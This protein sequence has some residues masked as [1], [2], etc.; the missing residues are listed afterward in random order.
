M[1]VQ[2]GK[3]VPVWGWAAPEEPVV[4]DWGGHTLRTQADLSGRWHLV[5]PAVAAG[6]VARFS[7]T[8][9]NRIEVKDVLAGEVWLGSGQSNMGFSVSRVEDFERV[10]AAANLPEIRM[11]VVEKK[12]ADKPEDDCVGRWIVCSP[13]SVGDFSAVAFFFGRTMHETM[14]GAVGLIV[15]SAGATPIESWISLAKQRTWPRF[16]KYADLLRTAPPKVSRSEASKQRALELAKLT[17]PGVLFN[18]MIAPLIPY[19]IRGVLWYQ[20]ESNANDRYVAFYE[21]QMR[22]LV[23]DWRA[24][25]GEELPFAWV[26]L[27]N[28]TARGRT[29]WPELR[30]AQRRA[31]TLPRTGMVVTID[32]GDPNDIHPRNKQDVGRRLAMWAAGTVYGR[33]VAIS[34]PLP[35]ECVAEGKAVVARFSH[36]DG[37]MARGGGV[38]GFELAGGDGIWKPAQAVI[39]AAT[40]RISSAGISDPVAVRYG[41]ASNPKGN[42]CNGAGLPAS[43]FMEVV[44]KQRETRH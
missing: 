17:K 8:A 7:I 34:G 28:F 30:E 13:D 38:A 20:G 10:R 4:I 21:D 32:I 44:N 19:G 5:L 16:E 43:P 37:L 41:W 6:S 24:R 22:L 18:A 1:V 25:W 33:D 9:S 42:L 12:P 15:S 31:L 27:A 35:A 11:F 14:G 29:G 2:A 40:V 39:A 26:Q 3:P 23:E 36:A